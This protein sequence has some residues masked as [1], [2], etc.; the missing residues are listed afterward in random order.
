MFGFVVKWPSLLDRKSK[1][2][3]FDYTYVQSN[4]FCVFN[5]VIVGK[6]SHLARINVIEPVLK[7]DVSRSG[8]QFALVDVVLDG[9]L[10]DVADA[11]LLGQDEEGATGVAF[12]PRLAVD[13]WRHRFVRGHRSEGGTLAEGEARDLRLLRVGHGE[14]YSKN[15]GKYDFR[16]LHFHVTW[17]K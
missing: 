2:E 6:G 12:A 15:G 7:V 5:S 14:N 8:D 10:D 3:L 4:S 1:L 13:Q 9:A 17:K 11:F 16:K